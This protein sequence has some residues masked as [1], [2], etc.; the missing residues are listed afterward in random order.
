[1][2][3]KL[4]FVFATLPIFALAQHTVKGK[5]PNT[6]DFKFAFLYQ[7]TTQT[8]KFVNNAEIKEDGTFTFIL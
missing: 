4:I 8:S 3:K 2:L 7:V 6:D 1:M 5:F